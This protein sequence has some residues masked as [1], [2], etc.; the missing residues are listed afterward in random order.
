MDAVR[1]SWREFL[2]SFEGRVSLRQF[3]WR[4]VIPYTVISFVISLSAPVIGAFALYLM[5]LFTVLGLWPSA[6]VGVKRW[7]DRGK[8]GWWCLIM[9]LPV[10]GWLYMFLEMACLPGTK[11]ANAYGSPVGVS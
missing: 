3:W 5:G 7:H 8:S 11:E 10:I 9:L 2:F 4:F 6:A 1:F